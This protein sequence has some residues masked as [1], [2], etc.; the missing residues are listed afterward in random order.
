MQTPLLNPQ[1]SFSSAEGVPDLIPASSWTV[2]IL[3]LLTFLILYIGAMGYKD[4]GSSGP[5]GIYQ[6]GEG[7]TNGPYGPINTPTTLS[8]PGSLGRPLQGMLRFL[9]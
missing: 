5:P 2:Q 3:V 4:K 7:Y 1:G 8:S 6:Y 9:G